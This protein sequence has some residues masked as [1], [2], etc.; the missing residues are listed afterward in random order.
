[1]EVVQQWQ[2]LLATGPTRL[3]G[4]GVWL[5]LMAALLIPLERRWPLRRQSTLRAYFNMWAKRHWPKGIL[6]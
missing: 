2:Q 3:L 4:L 6:C 5:L 1:M